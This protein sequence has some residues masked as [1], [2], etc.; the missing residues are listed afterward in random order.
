MP[1]KSA[2]LDVVRELALA[3]PDV[4]ESTSWGAMSFK[5]GGRMFAC[6]AIHSSAEPGSLMVRIDTK[7]R[8]E[9]LAAQPEIYYLTPHY[10]PYPALLVRLARVSRATLAKV[11]GTSCLFVGS[12]G[13]AR[14]RG[15]RKAGGKTKSRPRG[16]ARGR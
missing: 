15:R 7:L 10:A 12:S 2:D 5:V 16:S 13:P 3:L 6:Q 14:T 8:D 11:L 9:L 1:R 4:E